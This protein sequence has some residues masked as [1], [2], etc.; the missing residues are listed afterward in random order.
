MN[1][2]NQRVAAANET[3]HIIEQQFYS[4]NKGKRVD[5]ADDL[6]YAKHHSQL[7][8]G[9]DFSLVFAERTN[10]LAKKIATNTLF[11]VTPETTLQATERLSISHDKVFCLNFASAKN[12]GGGF[13]G[14]SQAQ[15]ES[16]ARSSALYPCI[17]QMVEMYQ[18]NK[19]QSSCL[20]SD[21]MIYSP[22][23][24]VFKKDDGVL[25]NQYYKVSFLTSPAVN[26]GVVREREQDKIKSI[27]AVMKTRLDKILSIAV[28]KGYKVLVLGAWGCGVFRN[29]PTDVVG[30]FRYHL[31]E[32]GLFKDYF[33]KI[34]FAVYD[35][36]KDKQVIQAFL[37]G[38]N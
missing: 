21:D 30:Y 34:V 7:F 18:N 24:P 20:Y 13:L 25:L 35:P 4:N 31:M 27:D 14:G 3:L 15:E 38:I 22:N 26:A 2:R 8:R 12:P 37:K 28:V 10:I 17:S 6:A 16:L 19:H 32:Q 29:N 33:D 11:E 36:S 1:D 9:D 23:V 5:I